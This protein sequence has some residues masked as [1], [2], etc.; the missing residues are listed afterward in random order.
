MLPEEADAIQAAADTA[1]ESVA[2]YITGAIRGRMKGQL[3][4]NVD[5]NTDILTPEAIKAAK[6][7]AALQGE[8]L[9]EFLARAIRDTAE[10]DEKI[11]PLLKP[12]KTQ[13]PPKKEEMPAFNGDFHARHQEYLNRAKEGSK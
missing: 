7:A 6:E 11:R 3:P 1:G 13:E 5:M 10:R 2:K 12:Q 4:V 8:E 9:G